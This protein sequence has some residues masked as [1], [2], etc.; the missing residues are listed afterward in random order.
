MVWSGCRM[1]VMDL[2]NLERQLKSLAN[3]NRLRILS[4]LKRKHSM[5]VSDIASHLKIT[6]AAASRHLQI[7]EQAEIVVS[8]KRGLFVTYR[9]LL[10]GEPWTRAV[11]SSLSS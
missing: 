6:I 5:T 7:L 10:T 11:L 4:A 9:L 2:K 3:G 1:T 8:R